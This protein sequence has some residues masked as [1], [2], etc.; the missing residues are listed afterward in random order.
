MVFQK[1]RTLYINFIFKT[2]GFKHNLLP[3]SCDGTVR[4]GVGNLFESGANLQVPGLLRGHTALTPAD[5]HP[6]PQPCCPPH[7]TTTAPHLPGLPDHPKSGLRRRKCLMA[8][9]TGQKPVSAVADGGKAAPLKKLGERSGATSRL[10]GG[11][12]WCAG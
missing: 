6:T 8:Q 11:R 4:S 2:Q 5:P 3:A 9:R 12:T 10:P 7:P 1:K